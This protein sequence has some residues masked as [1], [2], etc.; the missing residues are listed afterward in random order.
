MIV[1]D[2][3][4]I[5]LLSEAVKE[6]M[7]ATVDKLLKTITSIAKEDINDEI[8][9]S[10]TQRCTWFVNRLFSSVSDLF[11]IDN[12]CSSVQ[13]SNIDNTLV[14]KKDGEEIEG[15]NKALLTILVTTYNLACETCPKKSDQLIKAYAKS[16]KEAF[17][18]KVASSIYPINQDTISFKCSCKSDFAQIIAYTIGILLLSEK[19]DVYEMSLLLLLTR[20]LKNKVSACKY[21][22]VV[23]PKTEIFTQLSTAEVKDDIVENF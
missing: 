16:V 20:V 23:L 8:R 5:R 9:Q 14:V 3:N 15:A 18:E 19:F 21:L 11:E 13:F 4:S 1:L 10:L 6:D 12:S 7:D 17:E 2:K 22:A